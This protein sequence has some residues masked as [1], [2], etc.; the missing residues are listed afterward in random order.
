MSTSPQPARRFEVQVMPSLL[1]LRK[2]QVIGR[3]AGAAPAGLLR[4]WVEKTLPDSGPA[5]LRKGVR[6]SSRPACAG[7]STAPTGF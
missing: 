1:V 2:G 7:S 6:G 5:R 3:Q 4:P